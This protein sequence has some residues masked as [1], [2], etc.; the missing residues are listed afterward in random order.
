[1]RVYW[2]GADLAH[3]YHALYPDQRWAYDL[4]IEPAG[5]GSPRVEDYGCWDQPVLAP[6]TGV[7][8]SIHDGDPDGTPGVV[9]E[10][11]NYAGNHVVVKS[12]ATGTYL[13]VAHLERGTVAVKPGDRIEE[14]QP[15][16]RCGNSGRSSE[17][18][19][20]LHHQRQEVGPFPIG[21]AEGLPLFFRDHRGPAMP[22][23]GVEKRGDR[24]ILLGDVIEHAPKQAENFW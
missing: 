11:E 8:S 13:I 10:T 12:D 20:H 4:V 6:I 19:V 24:I 22:S 5:L 21:L 14:G 18:H 16:G 17:P 3:N 9:A 23:G 1:M 7:V 2:G 15:I